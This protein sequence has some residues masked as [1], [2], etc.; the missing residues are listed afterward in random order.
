MTVITDKLNTLLGPAD[1]VT[2]GVIRI[3]GSEY[4]VKTAEVDEIPESFEIGEW[5]VK[6]GKL[7]KNEKFEKMPSFKELVAEVRGVK[8]NVEELKAAK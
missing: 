8:Q 3:N 7:V 5:Y 2:G 6:K 4:E 1:G